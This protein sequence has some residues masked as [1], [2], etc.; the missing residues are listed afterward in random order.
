MLVGAAVAI[1]IIY[2]K[3]IVQHLQDDINKSL[4]ANVSF[5]DD[6][7]ISIFRAFPKLSV[8]VEDILV[9]GKESFSSDTLVKCKKLEATILLSDLFNDGKISIQHAALNQA[10]L[11]LIS[12]NGLNNW[13]ITKPSD[14]EESSISMAADFKELLL[15]DATFIYDDS[16]ASTQVAFTN[17]TGSFVGAYVNDSFDLT[18]TLFCKDA[19]LEYDN[20]PYVGHLP[21]HLDAVTAMNFKDWK[22]NFKE[23]EFRVGNVSLSGDGGMAFIG[24]SISMDINFASNN[25]SVHDLL[26]FIPA[27]YTEDLNDIT[28]DGTGKVSGNIK[29][30]VSDTELPGYQ[31]DVLL[32][33]G[34][35]KHKDH[36]QRIQ[37][38]NLDLSIL[39]KDGKDESLIVNAKNFG[40]NI[41]NNS[42]KG[43]VVYHPMLAHPLLKS[44]I[45]GRINLA[46]IN[47]F[48][49]KQYQIGV[50]GLLEGDIK[51]DGSTSPETI[52]NMIAS[53]SFKAKDVVYTDPTFP[54]SIEIPN[55]ELLITNNTI[56]I[57]VCAIKANK[58]DANLSGR[59]NNWL[60][61]AL[62]D[63]K[64]NG[65][66]TITSTALNASDF[67][68]VSDDTTSTDAALELPENMDVRLTYNIKELVYDDHV[69]ASIKGMSNLQNGRVLINEFSTE[70]LGGQV[71]LNGLYEPKANSKSF[72]DMQLI[73]QNLNVQQAFKQFETIRIL[74]PIAEHV[75]GLFSSSITV[76]TDLLSDFSPDLSSISCKGILDL[77]QCNVEGLQSVQTIGN[78]L[79][80]QGLN[81]P[82]ALEKL[83]MSF[84]ILDGKI[85]V[86]PFDVP[87]G[88][89]ILQ[90]AGFSRLDKTIQ[91]D[92]ILRVPKAV[93]QQKS[94]NYNAFIPENQ[95]AQLKNV[96]WSDLDF[97]VNIT[98]SYSK[99]KVNIDFKKTQNKLV[100]Q[101][102]SKITNAI[103]TKKQELQ[104]NAQAEI[105]KA[106]ADAEAAKK[107]AEEKARIALEEQKKKLAEQAEREKAAA[108]KAAEDALNKK[109]N[110]LLKKT[111]PPR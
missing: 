61:Y 85:N 44:A 60:G 102:K 58:S 8:G 66:L 89:S 109:K 49:P 111:L 50:K 100:D 68:V 46:D 95:L 7:Q 108:K 30:I 56:D 62:E 55:A 3:E 43:N 24:D 75:K 101:A 59:C 22:F 4:E 17:L 23:N 94:K 18:S 32:K 86:S 103:D 6:I 84:S 48:I 87:L 97:D 90:L 10:Y 41:D 96:D 64:L 11:Q 70:C 34:N 98:G 76:Q 72:A 63:Q 21:V 15:E 80:I 31:M 1:P 78:K 28:A 13:D 40:F 16:S 39:N 57:P 12:R 14:D 27:Y 93:Y 104:K 37:N 54:H 92:G 81:K 65:A 82:I 26:S 106:R 69:F 35:V 77:F 19:Y 2:K 20:I 53:G 33:D 79:D 99:P 88:E 38:L 51:V 74:A 110:E 91:F 36:S 105:D 42:L 47:V 29:G 71:V 52:Q 25:A 45:Q 5:N 67:M 9:V 107:A 83:L 73:V